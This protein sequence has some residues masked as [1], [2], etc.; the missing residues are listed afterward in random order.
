MKNVSALFCLFFLE[1][2]GK[3]GKRDYIKM[4][5]RK[6][7]VPP[8][9]S[10]KFF[11][12][13]AVCTAFLLTACGPEPTA[14]EWMRRSLASAKEAKWNRALDQAV[15]AVEK[16]PG[17]T[18]ANVLLAIALEN[19][20]RPEDALNAAV[21][22]GADTSSFIAQYTLG[23]IYC[24]QQKYDSSVKPLTRAL[25]LRPDDAN[26]L[27]LLAR[28]KLRLNTEDALNLNK[29]LLAIPQFSQSAVIYNELGVLQVLKGEPKKA[30]ALFLKALSL[31]ADNPHLNLNNA[32][33]HDYHL[34]DLMKAR[35]YYNSFLRLAA[36]R[37]ELLD[38]YKEV[39]TRLEIIR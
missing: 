23:R 31:D 9:K 36:N 13:A 14:D 1:S 21:R 34:G 38:E 33:L 39:Q 24:R 11:C 3:N 27:I 28:A 15:N 26:T 12:F 2:A 6:G 35:Q 4:G 18:L 19:N 16:A 25:E 30:T 37:R 32:I 17:N 5:Q 10:L 29:R 7:D 20:N 8:M 22:A